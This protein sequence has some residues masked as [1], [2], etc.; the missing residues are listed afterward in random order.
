MAGNKFLITEADNARNFFVW[1]LAYG[2][3]WVLWLP[4]FSQMQCQTP[5]YSTKAS[6]FYKKSLNLQKQKFN[7][8]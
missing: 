2:Q 8:N 7:I 3:G 5:Q 4:G 1:V 6:L